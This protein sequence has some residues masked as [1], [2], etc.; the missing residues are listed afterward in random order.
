MMVSLGALLCGGCYDPDPPGD[1]DDGGS[2]E[3]GTVASSES[4]DQGDGGEDAGSSSGSP[5]GDSSGEP[6]GDPTGLPP[7]DS[8]DSGDTGPTQGTCDAGEVCI[9]DAPVGWSGPSAVYR[10]AEP[11]PSCPATLPTIG[12]TASADLIA[13]EADCGCEC[14]DAQGYTCTNTVREQGQSD[15]LLP[16]FNADSW[17][18]DSGECQTMSTGS[19]VFGST[20]PA[21]DTAGA[22][23]APNANEFVTEPSWGMNVQ[24][25]DVPEDA[26]SCDGGLCTAT[27]TDPYEAVCIHVE[28]DA[29][30]PEGP[31]SEREVVYTGIADDRGCSECSCGEPAGTC[32]GNVYF[33]STCGTLPVLYESGPAGGCIDVGQVPGAVSYSAQP[34]VTCAPSGGTPTGAAEGTGPITLCCLP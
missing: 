5:D 29:M 14:D 21:L 34:D 26:P 27:P 32:N 31:Y 6:P 3:S 2:S 4:G 8:D 19:I 23:C 16:I 10:G 11:P 24:G 15:C 13:P 30:C 1:T 9:P 28:G 12:V 33:Q 20:T 7:D 22:S 18:L 25:C 17:T